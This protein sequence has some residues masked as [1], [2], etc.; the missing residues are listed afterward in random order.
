MATPS[1]EG[2]GSDPVTSSEELLGDEGM[3]VGVD[4]VAAVVSVSLPGETSPEGQG[5]STEIAGNTVPEISI[6]ICCS[7]VVV[8]HGER[9]D[10]DLNVQLL[11]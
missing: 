8:E 2:P 9:A 4:E 7:S 5:H 11:F 10:R 6:E 1:K 3:L